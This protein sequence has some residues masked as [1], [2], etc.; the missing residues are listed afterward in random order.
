MF[1]AYHIGLDI[2]NCMTA[3][4][5][6]EVTLKDEHFIALAELILHSWPFTKCEEQKEL[7]PYWSFWDEIAIIE[8]TAIK[9]RIIIIPVSLQVNIIINI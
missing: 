3:E 6:K 1:E 4:E 9:G 7:Q 2:P 5:I 8:R